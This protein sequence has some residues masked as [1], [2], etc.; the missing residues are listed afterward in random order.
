MP[1]ARGVPQGAGKGCPETWPQ[2]REHRTSSGPNYLPLWEDTTKTQSPKA[3]YQRGGSRAGGSGPWVLAVPGRSESRLH[4]LPA[5]W[6]RVWRTWVGADLLL[7]RTCLVRCK[8]STST[9]QKD[10][11]TAS[12]AGH[13]PATVIAGLWLAVRAPQPAAPHLCGPGGEGGQQRGPQGRPA[14]SHDE[15]GLARAPCSI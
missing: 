14:L 3:A 13:R 4:P 1:R 10:K 6:V 9:A 8:E 2:R 11:L 12:F 7:S 15:P 5:Q